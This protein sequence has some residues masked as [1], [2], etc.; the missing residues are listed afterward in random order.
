[1]KWILFL[2][3]ASSSTSF[4]QTG[5]IRCRIK[6]TDSAVIK[7]G[8]A[9]LYLLDSTNVRD[10]T[11]PT[12]KTLID[13][14]GMVDFCDLPVGLYAVE[15]ERYEYITSYTYKIPVKQ[16]EMTTVNFI[17]K[18]TREIPHIE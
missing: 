7:Y 3:I 11:T 2:L 9:R 14:N 4:A 8:I 1:M 5:N 6:G 13:K 17:L 16:G 10:A 12:Q 18:S 15:I